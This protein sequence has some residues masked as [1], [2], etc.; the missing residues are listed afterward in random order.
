MTETTPEE[1]DEPRAGTAEEIDADGSDGSTDRPAGT[2]D[3][4]DYSGVG[5]QEP[6]DPESPTLQPGG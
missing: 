2:S 4:E 3:P 1:P 5:G 6:I